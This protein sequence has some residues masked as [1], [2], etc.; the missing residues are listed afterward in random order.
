MNYTELS[1]AIQDYTE[2]DEATFI[3]NIPNFVRQAETTIY[4]NTQ[5]PV[6]RKNAAGQFTTSNRYLTL[7][8]DFLAP[9]E[10]FVTGSGS[11]QAPLLFKD[12]SWIREAFPDPTV[13]GVP[14]YYAMFDESTFIV[15]RTPASNYE[16]EI[17]YYHHPESIVT[18]TTTWLGDNYENVLLHGSLVLAY[19]FMK[20][21]KDLIE[22]YD[23]QFKQG[24]TLLKKLG[25]GMN[26][27]DTYRT[28]QTRTGV[29]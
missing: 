1:Q 8:S 4:T 12:V 11:I 10:L 29:V 22:L 21:E 9:Y 7:P 14:R 2:N 5:L 13:T 28:A 20:G 24:L 18:A 6:L 23:A 17:H 19:E 25:D 15:G 26:R 16:A 3:T 27:M